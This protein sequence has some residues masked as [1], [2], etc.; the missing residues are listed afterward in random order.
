MKVAEENQ[1]TF[2]KRE[3]KQE[4]RQ[5]SRSGLLLPH[6]EDAELNLSM[7]QTCELHREILLKKKEEEEK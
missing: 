3:E 4:F 7:S 5:R 6:T 2:P 1:R